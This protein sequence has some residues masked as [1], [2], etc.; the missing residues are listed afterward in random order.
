MNDDIS[1]ALYGEIVRS[2]GSV[3]DMERALEQRA[4]HLIATKDARLRLTAVGETAVGTIL[5][6]NEEALDYAVLSKRF[7]LILTN[8]PRY[9]HP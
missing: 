2:F 9:P 6:Q 4:V 7:A 8:R 3:Q 1:P 5:K